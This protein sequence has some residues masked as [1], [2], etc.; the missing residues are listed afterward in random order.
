VTYDGWAMLDP[1][2]L[3]ARMEALLAMA[4]SDQR[5]IPLLNRIMDPLSNDYIPWTTFISQDT[6]GAGHATG[7]FVDIIPYI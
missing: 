7:S 5:R 4:P 6:D 2:T 3:G 1:R